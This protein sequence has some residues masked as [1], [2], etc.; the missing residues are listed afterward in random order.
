MKVII[1]NPGEPIGH[2]EEIKNDLHALQRKVGGYVEAV[3][4]KPDLVMLCDE[5]GIDKGAEKNFLMEFRSGK[6]QWIRG[7]VL[8]CGAD[9]EE[10]TDVTTNL[11]TWELYLLMWGNETKE[12]MK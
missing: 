10:F 2:Y 6:H 7:M 1:K 12:E 4:I 3:T 9:G 11:E 5:D 8:I